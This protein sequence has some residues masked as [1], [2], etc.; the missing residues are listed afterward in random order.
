M[1]YEDGRLL[2][3]ECPKDLRLSLDYCSWTA[4]ELVKGL[5]SLPVGAHFLQYSF[6]DSPKLGFFLYTS[7]HSVI[8]RKWSAE[9]LRAP[10]PEE[11]ELLVRAAVEGDFD[12]FLGDFPREKADLWREL[13]GFVTKEVIDRL[14]PDMRSLYSA[15]KCSEDGSSD[16]PTVFYTPVPQRKAGAG[17]S[18][19]EVTAANFDKSMILEDLMDGGTRPWQDL[20]GEFQYAFISLLLVEHEAAFEQW[21]RLLTVFCSCERALCTHTE[22]FNALIRKHY[23]AVLYHQLSQLGT[24]ADDPLLATSFIPQLIQA[25]LSLLDSPQLPKSLYARGKKL[26]KLVREMWGDWDYEEGEDAPVIVELSDEQLA[27]L[28]AP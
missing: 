2:L 1:D 24:I 3:L 12:L 4:C 22:F 23:A 10:S 25:F 20:M 6:P 28:S 9:E 15:E 16:G 21:K 27:S 13:T 14:Q 11:E 7:K 8:V 19:A 18:P 26:D 17:M 5:K